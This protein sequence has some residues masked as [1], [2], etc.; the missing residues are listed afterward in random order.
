VPFVTCGIGSQ[1][2]LDEDSRSSKYRHKASYGVGADEREP[3]GG[4]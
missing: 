2:A 1:Q 4:T 3:E